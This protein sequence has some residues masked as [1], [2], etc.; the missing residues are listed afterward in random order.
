MPFHHFT[1]ANEKS[2]YRLNTNTSGSCPQ[3]FAEN[4][5]NGSHP[6][7]E[8]QPGSVPT[9]SFLCH[10]LSCIPVQHFPFTHPDVTCHWNW[11]QHPWMVL[12][13]SLLSVLDQAKHQRSEGA[14]AQGNCSASTSELT[15]QSWEA[16]TKLSFPS[17]S[18]NLLA[19]GMWL[20]RYSQ[21]K[22]TLPSSACFCMPLSLPWRGLHPL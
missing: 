2:I 21:L 22:L 20:S 5:E 6:F 3:D 19:H 18:E 4:L 11:E 14:E 17:P 15:A 16:L 13:K 12:E 7:Q 9:F 1:H 10:F 8:V